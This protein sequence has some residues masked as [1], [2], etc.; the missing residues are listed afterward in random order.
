M[1]GWRFAKRKWRGSYSYGDQRALVLFKYLFIKSFKLLSCLG[2]TYVSP[3]HLIGASSCGERERSDSPVIQHDVRVQLPQRIFTDFV[4]TERN[5]YVIIQL[6]RMF[7]SGFA[8]NIIPVFKTNK[9]PCCC[10][11][12]T[13]RPVCWCS[14]LRGETVP[15]PRADLG[16]LW[17]LC[18]GTQEDSAKGVTQWA[19]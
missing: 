13:A 7:H 14:A 15:E 8:S 5:I 11:A 16:H 12:A 2:R 9:N 1:V 6:Y 17:G 19:K 3:V 18:P 10:L 4:T